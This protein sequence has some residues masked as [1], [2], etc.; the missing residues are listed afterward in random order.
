M[1]IKTK[2]KLVLGISIP[3]WAFFK[4]FSMRGTTA[5]IAKFDLSDRQAINDFIINNNTEITRILH[6]KDEECALCNEGE[7]IEVNGQHFS[8]YISVF[9]ETKCHLV[10]VTNQ[11]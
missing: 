8:H 2:I 6:P 9:N 11:V 4:L 10:R 7:L 3:F 5:P 1:K